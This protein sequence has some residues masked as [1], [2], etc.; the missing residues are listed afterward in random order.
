M[1]LKKIEKKAL[2]FSGIF[3]LCTG[4]FSGDVL[5]AGLADRAAA[6]MLAPHRAIYEIRLVSA[7][8]GS[9]LVNVSGRMMYEWRPTCDAWISKH[10][11]DIAY[12]YADTPPMTISSDFS[13]FEPFDGKSMDFTSQRRKDGVLYEELRGRAEHEA[14]TGTA[15]YT[16]PPDL[17]FD[18]PEGTLFPVGHTLAVLEAQQAGTKFFKSVI[19][20]GSDDQGPVEVT[21]FLGASVDDKDKYK[22]NKDI[23]AN[24]MTGEAW[25]ARLAFFPLD[26]MSETSDYEMSLVFHENGIITDMVIN[27][28]DF[29]IS[30]DLV[31]LEPVES[32]CT[33]DAPQGKEKP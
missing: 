7:Q 6:A 8:S 27:Y 9:Q 31:A 19:F 30:Q 25:K 16:M 10:R 2:A 5:A 21:S 20:D 29:T 23:D 33:P 4:L 28:D 22:G 24:L 3:C 18:L 12:E 15:S 32:D 11:F 17:D 26:E 13:T 1:F 14:K